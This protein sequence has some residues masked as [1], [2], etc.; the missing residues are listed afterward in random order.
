MKLCP[1]CKTPNATS[2]EEE[3]KRVEKLMEK[4]NPNAFNQL[5]GYYEDGTMGLPQDW[6][7]ANEL[8][9]KAGE[10]GC[11]MAYY[12][13]GT[14]YY[15]GRDVEV[16]KKKAKYYYELAAVN[17]DVNARHILGMME[18]Q[19]GNYQ[20][21][22]KHCLISTKSGD[23][24]SLDGVKKG[25]MSGYITKEQ[26]ANTLREYQNSQDEMKSDAR[27]KALAV[28]NHRMGG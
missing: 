28:R 13:L 8:Y 20:R 15:A 10:L 22:M 26:Y 24:R 4:G 27:D 3:V 7:K 9:L 1:F 25:Y 18:G 2:E 21:A 19:A 17:G 12:N 23:D 16:D 5:A 14:L 11:A 6:A